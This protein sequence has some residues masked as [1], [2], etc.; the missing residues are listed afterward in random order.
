MYARKSEKEVKQLVARQ[1]VAKNFAKKKDDEATALI[2]QLSEER[3]R[4]F[5]ARRSRE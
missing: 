3:K 1:Q 4:C 2:N 5:A